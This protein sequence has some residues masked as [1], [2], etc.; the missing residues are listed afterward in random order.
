[1]LRYVTLRYVMLCY[2][3]LI[4]FWRCLHVCFSRIYQ[5]CQQEMSLQACF[6]ACLGYICSKDDSWLL[7]KIR[8]PVRSYII[9]HCSSFVARDKIEVG[10][11]LVRTI[12][13]LVKLR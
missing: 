10:T 8:E 1:M 4:L 2:M 9:D 13:S 11:D 12:T 7:K 3:Q 5:I 6:Y